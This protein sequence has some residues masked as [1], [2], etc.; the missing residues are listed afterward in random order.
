MWFQEAKE[1]GYDQAKLDVPHLSE[2][3][4]EMC[5][6]QNL[7]KISV[8]A[9]T[10]RA[11][12]ARTTFYN[13]F[14]DINELINYIPISYFTNSSLVLFSPELTRQ[15]F[16]YACAHKG[17]FCQ[18]PRHFGQNNFRETFT[19]WLQEA[20]YR[21]FLGGGLSERERAIRQLRI[22]LQCAGTVELFLNWC[23]SGMKVPTDVLVEALLRSTPDFMCEGATGDAPG[24]FESFA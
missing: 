3:F 9:L 2:T 19:A 16:E 10:R 18:L 14:S 22:D 17:F 20:G 5:E 4:M 23:L 7:S 12:V 6:E 11:N 1:R 21:L 8:V 15:A 13:N 24:P